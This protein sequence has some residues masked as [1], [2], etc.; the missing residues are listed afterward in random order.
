MPPSLCGPQGDI[1]PTACKGQGTQLVW[2]WTPPHCPHWSAR[3]SRSGVC[4][5][6]MCCSEFSLA[7]PS[8]TLISPLP[9]AKNTFHL[10]KS[11]TVLTTGVLSYTPVTFVLPGDVIIIC[12]PDSDHPWGQQS[13][14][15]TLAS[16]P[17]LPHRTS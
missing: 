17:T 11:V 16:Q 14:S 2:T 3:A 7:F 5:H 4:S 12:C 15:I 9:P 10:L 6:A 8:L 13:P 1:Q